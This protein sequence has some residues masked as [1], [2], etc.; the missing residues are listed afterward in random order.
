MIAQETGNRGS[1]RRL[2]ANECRLGAQYGDPLAALDY[3]TV[4]ISQSITTRATPP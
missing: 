1:D 3:F 4:A 2:A